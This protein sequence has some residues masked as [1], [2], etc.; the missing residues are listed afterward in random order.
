MIYCIHMTTRGSTLS[1]R[2]DDA[3]KKK[4][5][6]LAKNTGRSRAFL[7]AQAIHEYLDVNEWQVA[8]IKRAIAALD[9]GRGIAHD[10]VRAWIQSWG[11]DEHPMPTIT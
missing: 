9:A 5:E 6:K 7:A 11:A 1:V 4:L 2:V 8:R 3:I 10:E